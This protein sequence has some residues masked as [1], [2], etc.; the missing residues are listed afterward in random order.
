TRFIHESYFFDPRLRST[1]LHR[2][3]FETGQLGRKSGRGFFR[4]DGVP[5]ADTGF[6]AD[7]VTAVCMHGGSTA[8]RELIAEC[9]AKS[10]DADDGFS[11]ILIAPIGDDCS[12]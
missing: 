10:I 11:P 4:Y 6:T 12:S 7:P 2:Y 5:P 9:G 3:M 8:L 1:P